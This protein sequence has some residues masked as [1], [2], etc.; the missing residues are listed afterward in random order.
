MEDERYEWMFSMGRFWS[1]VKLCMELGYCIRGD[2]CLVAIEM[3]SDTIYSLCL[4]KCLWSQSSKA[5]PSARLGGFFV[6]VLQ[7]WMQIIFNTVAKDN[8]ESS[9][10]ICQLLYVSIKNAKGVQHWNQTA[11]PENSYIFVEF[12]LSLDWCAGQALDLSGYDAHMDLLHLL[13][14]GPRFAY[15]WHYMLQMCNDM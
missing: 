1:D 11:P 5:Q 10:T 14:T 9:L 13:K 6:V 7:Q 8:L 12:H 2:T 15:V 3:L 4:A